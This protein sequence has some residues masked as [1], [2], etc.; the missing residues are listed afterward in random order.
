MGNKLDMKMD[1]SRFE[2]LDFIE[3]DVQDGANSGTGGKA[4]VVASTASP[5]FAAI[6]AGQLAEV[7]S[8]VEGGAALSTVDDSGVGLIAAAAR[9]AKIQI[10][11]YLLSRGAPVTSASAEE[12]PALFAAVGS[13]S[14]EVVNLILEASADVEQRYGDF[15]STVLHYAVEKKQAGILSE[16]LSSQCKCR[17]LINVRSDFGTPL[18]TAASKGC[19]DAVELLISRNAD[20]TMATEEGVSAL[21]AAFKANQPQLAN[22]LMKAGARLTGTAVYEACMHGE[23]TL[24]QLVQSQAGWVNAVDG[25]SCKS[26]LHIASIAGDTPLIKYL[27]ESG[28]NV[29][30]GSRAAAANDWVARD[31]VTPL[32]SASRYGHKGCTRCL[33]QFKANA[34]ARCC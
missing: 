1:F 20:V 18:V 31:G 10:V 14:L 30:M 22:K 15:N 33:L 11:K 32:M 25:S 13:G 23:E 12:L 16:L 27:C 29:D 9:G 19:L 6:K 26:A 7:Q 28:A 2:Q 34:D 24:D 4:K 3:L 21:S 5:I 17:G 8:A